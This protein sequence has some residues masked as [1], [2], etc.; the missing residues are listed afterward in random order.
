MEQH[1]GAIIRLKA[2]VSQLS[3]KE[4]LAATYILTQPDDVVRQSITELADAIGVAE[5]TIFRL[6]KRIGF[7]GYQGFKIALAR[8]VVK[9]I[10]NIYQEINEEDPAATLMTKVFHAHVQGLQDT[11][12]LYDDYLLETAMTRMAAA[13]RIQFYGTGGSAVIAHDAVHK[14]IRT[15]LQCQAFEDSHMQVMAATMLGP[16]SVA[17]GISHS[18]SN[19]DILQALE[20]AKSQGAYIIALT[21]HA[22]SPITKIADL[23]LQTNSTETLYRSEALTSRLIQLA[24][25]DV[26]YVG[27][28]MK[29]KEKTLEG[30]EKI[31]EAIALK[32]V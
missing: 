25:I 10:E 15:G 12:H 26:L 29:R 28:A 21:Q 27:I 11:L 6:C 19:K 18:G 7:K 14:L 30:L 16:D 22:R 31:R 8:D 23:V 3:K 1:E 13:D 24:V 2:I 5:S 17:F 4:Q 32:R 20:T 9:P